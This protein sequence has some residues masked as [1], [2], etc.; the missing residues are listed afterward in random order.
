MPVASSARGGY[1]DAVVFLCP[2]SSCSPEG[3]RQCRA[4]S[5]AQSRLQ[6]TGTCAQRLLAPHAC[7]P[8]A[9]L[10]GCEASTPG[11]TGETA[12]AGLW[13]REH[14]IEA[15]HGPGVLAFALQGSVCCRPA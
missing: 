15:H 4:G 12:G 7:N 8:R 6:Q 13:V 5:V 11:E 1:S 10:A 3:A 9:R 14:N 2:A